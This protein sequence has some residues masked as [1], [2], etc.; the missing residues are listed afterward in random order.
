MYQVEEKE[1]LELFTLN[2]RD[3]EIVRTTQVW[4][5]TLN[6]AQEK[7]EDLGLEVLD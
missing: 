2:V 6:E 1:S 7:V 3:G 5:Y 4:A